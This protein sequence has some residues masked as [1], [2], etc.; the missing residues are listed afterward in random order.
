MFAI[1]VIA[2]LF[3]PSA[4]EARC[5]SYTE[6]SLPSQ[7]RSVVPPLVA[8]I[9]GGGALQAPIKPEGG[10]AVCDDATVVSDDWPVLPG[11]GINVWRVDRATGEEW[12]FGVYSNG[13]VDPSIICTMHRCT[14]TDVPIVLQPPDMVDEVLRFLSEYIADLSSAVVTGDMRQVFSLLVFLAAIML[15]P[16]VGM[17]MAR[18]LF[19]IGVRLYANYHKPITPEQEDGLKRTRVFLEIL[20]FMVL[21]WFQLMIQMAGGC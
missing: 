9:D 13:N 3:L 17:F 1:L 5:P 11:G 4:L 8:C 20:V 2:I 18:A 12:S 10:G 16:M 7:A 19:L 14:T 6:L 21:F 15:P